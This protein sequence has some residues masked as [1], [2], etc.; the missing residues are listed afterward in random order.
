MI[1]DQVAIIEFPG[2]PGSTTDSADEDGAGMPCAS[3]R[4]IEYSSSVELPDCAE[5]CASK[6]TRDESAAKR[7]ARNAKAHLWR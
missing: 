6:D 4:G 3:C 5:S 1:H 7:V 2:T